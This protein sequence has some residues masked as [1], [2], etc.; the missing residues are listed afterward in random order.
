[1]LDRQIKKRTIYRQT[2]RQKKYMNRHP[3]IQRNR[4]TERQRRG[5]TYGK[6]ERKKNRIYI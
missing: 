2:I 3:D 5:K 1:M 4:Q 6:G